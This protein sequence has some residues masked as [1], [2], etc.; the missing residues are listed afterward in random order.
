MGK[1]I[2][3]LSTGFIGTWQRW[4]EPLHDPATEELI[5]CEVDEVEGLKPQAQLDAEAALVTD[6][7]RAAAMAVLEDESV[8]PTEIV[9]ALKAIVLLLVDEL[10]VLRQCNMVHR[11]IGASAASTVTALKNAWVN[12]LPVT[13]D[14]TPAQA[15]TAID[16]K[17]NA[18]LAD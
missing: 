1:A 17:I 5:E 2:R 9:V 10:N 15:K 8:S 6:A 12:N 11:A 4:G 16:A 14:R 13:N 3:N 18:G 7:K